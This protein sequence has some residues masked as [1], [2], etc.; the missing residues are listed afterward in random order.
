MRSTGTGTTADTW[1]MTALDLRPAPERVEG[2][3]WSQFLIALRRGSLTPRI[4][5]WNPGDHVALVGPTG[6]GK[7]TVAVGLLRLRQWVLAL[8]PKGEDETLSR[9]GFVRVTALPPPGWIQDEIAEGKPARLIVGGA[10]RSEAEDAALERLMREALD[11]TRHSG[12][13]T[14]YVDE[15]QLLGDQRMFRLGSRVERMLITARKDGTSVVTSFQA[16]AWVPRAAVRQATAFVILFATRDREMIK[17]TAQAMGRDWRQVCY[18]ID[19][20][21]RDERAEFTALVIPR[22]VRDPMLI[23]RAAKV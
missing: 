5:A 13:W 4:H 19:R 17:A 20:M 6:E 16:M 10:A 1:G 14:L 8:D 9:S 21:A 23:I 3:T 7:T 15:F 18:I 12:G 11:Y 22:S 2:V